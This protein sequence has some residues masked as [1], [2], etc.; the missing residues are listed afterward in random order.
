M[1]RILLDRNENAYGPAP[2]CLDVLRSI[3]VENLSHYDRL[4]ESLQIPEER[5]FLSNGSED[6]LKSVIHCYL[7]ETSRLLLPRQSWWYYKALAGEVRAGFIEYPLVEQDGAFHY[8]ADDII[9]LYIAHSPPIILIASPNNPTGNTITAEEFRKI[10]N[11]CTSSII[12]LDEA[13]H[14]FEPSS[15]PPLRE[16]IATYPNLVVVRSFSKYYALAGLRIGYAALGEDLLP[17][18]KYIHL[19][20]GHNRL[21]EE[22]A[23]AALDNE[24]YYEKISLCM[25]T[26][27]KRLHTRLSSLPG[28]HPYRSDANFL[29]ARLSPQTEHH[30]RAEFQ[31]H[32]IVAKFFTEPGF[33]HC[34]RLTIGTDD[35]TDTVLRALEQLPRSLHTIQLNPT[36]P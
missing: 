17:L 15:L 7:T 33:A 18:T 1:K 29:F 16:L 19:Y 30:L 11:R 35:D 32:D 25:R 28:C 23:L 36:H 9:D 34:L 6:M 2:G 26:S 31:R 3:S 24:A 4:S 27:K 8:N 10:M 5:L 12:V 13:Y 14:G 21:S 22:V 20:L